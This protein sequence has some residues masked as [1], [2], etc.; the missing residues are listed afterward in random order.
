MH[1]DTA[2]TYTLQ[3]TATDSCGN[4]TIEER[5]VIVSAPRTVLYTDGTFIINEKPEDMA[6]NIA[7]HGAATNVYDPFDP[8]G[9]TSD[10]KYIFPAES[11]RMWHA[12]RA[13]IKAVEI[14]SPIAPTD[15]SYW[16]ANF[17]TCT[18]AELSLLNTSAV[19]SMHNMF[20]YWRAL[21]S[22]DL[23]SFDTSAVTS[24]EGMFN[25]CDNLTS[26]DVSSFDTSKVTNMNEMFAYC[27]K[28][29]SVDVTNFDTS[30]LTDMGSMFNSCQMLT[31]L[32]LTSFDTSAV[33][34]M[35]W[36][37]GG[38]RALRTIYVSSAFVV[39]QVTSSAFMFN[40]TTNLVGGAGTTWSSSNPTDKTYAHIDGGTADPGYFTARP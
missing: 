32:D 12:E 34:R 31:N 36:L 29:T 39:S 19:T 15:T 1:I 5:T 11:M 3:Y 14:G 37:F 18:R 22:L 24:M 35:N 27:K 10:S 9:T 28:L 20:F 25:Y 8:N 23:T 17:T 13:L 33:T 30:R 6:G 40:N 2:G 26:I 16:F 4:E 21:T 38:C 7:L